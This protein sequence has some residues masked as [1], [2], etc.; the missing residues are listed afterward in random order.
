MRVEVWSCGFCSDRIYHVTKT[1][2]TIL[3]F[4]V[5]IDYEN[6]WVCYVINRHRFIHSWWLKFFPLHV[7]YDL[8]SC[9]ILGQQEVLYKYS[10]NTCTIITVELLPWNLVRKKCVT[11]YVKKNIQKPLIY[12]I[13]LFLFIYE[14]Y[15]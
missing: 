3:Y 15:L 4:G 11:A 6:S 12:Y 1:Y 14:Q 10:R 5:G 7:I 2:V 9:Q 8:P 13:T